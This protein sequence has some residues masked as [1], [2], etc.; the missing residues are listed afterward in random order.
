MVALEYEGGTW[1]KSRHTS[2]LGYEGDAV[3]Y[4]EAAI[5]GWKV[6]RVTLDMVNDGRAMDLVLRAVSNGVA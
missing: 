4:S 3:K 5:L 1:R 2:P 6:L